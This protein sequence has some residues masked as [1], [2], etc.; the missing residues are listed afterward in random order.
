VVASPSP[1]QYGEPVTVSVAVTATGP[2][3]PAGT[4][5]LLDGAAV[6][7]GPVPLD[8]SGQATF[9]LGA[10]SAGLHQL[11]ASFT[12]AAGFTSGTG[13]ASLTV[14]QAATGLA[15]ASSRNPSRAGRPV[16]FTATA[17]AA[18]ATPAGTVTF[19]DGQT[20]LGTAPLV[21]GVARLTT[22]GLR[23]GIHPVTAQLAPESGFVAAAATLEGGQLVENSAPVAGSGTALLLGPGHALRAAASVARALDQPTGTVE[24]WTR[25]EAAQPGAAPTLAR[26]GDATAARWA[27]GLTPARTGLTITL[28]A[29]TTAVP[30]DLSDGAWHQVALSA[31]EAAVT[32]LLDG[33][34]I[35]VIEGRLGS[36]PGETLTVGEG[37]AGELD[38]LRVWS[39]TRSAAEVAADARRPLQGREPWLLACW[40]MDEAEGLELFDAG[41]AGLDLAAA[42][43]PDAGAPTALGA[44]AAWRHR[45]AQRER[46]LDPV[47]AGYDADGDWMA[48]EI[49]AAPAHGTATTDHPNLQVGYL[50]AAGFSGADQLG[51]RLTDADG[52]V[53]EYTVDVTVERI[54]TCTVDA[55]CSGGDV[56]GGGSCVAPAELTAQSGGCGCTSGGGGGLALWS[57]LAL[58]LPLRR[59]RPGARQAGRQP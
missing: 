43:D 30:A 57:L 34:E 2:G 8:A 10:P 20:V 3:T 6:V 19:K 23:K 13:S 55:D 56:C 58:A 14:T 54:L 37:F 49:S 59:R 18:H 26:L 12:P 9:P 40:R 7:A 17:S 38:E 28:G 35:G 53:G 29:T 51:F 36:A 21:D 24:L 5:T 50:G 41:P 47:D 33:V 4:V 27:I 52:A 22:R 48:L 16:T 31:G 1:A 42:P 44:S 11:T 39:S 32:V 45:L 46:P 15:L 25:A